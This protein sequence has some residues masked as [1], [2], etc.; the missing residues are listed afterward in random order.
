M[1]ILAQIVVVLITTGFLGSCYEDPDCISLRNDILGIS[2]KTKSTNEEY[3]AEIVGITVSNTDSVFNAA[4]STKQI[5][6]PLDVNSG[7]Q[8]I[9]ID[10]AIG[11]FSMTVT[12]LSQPQFESVDCGPRFALSDLKVVEH[13]FDSAYVSG[14]IPL[15]GTS[16]TNIVVYPN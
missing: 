5:Y 12:Y 11:S 8:T 4:A 7:Q 2:F 9:N 14:A 3:T 10:L 6:L 16:G 1:K 15:S 13:T